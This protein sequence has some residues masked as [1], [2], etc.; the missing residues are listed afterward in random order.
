MSDCCFSRNQGKTCAVHSPRLGR[1]HPPE[2]HSSFLGLSTAAAPALNA[3]LLAQLLRTAEDVAKMQEELENSR[4]L[5]A[6]AAKDTEATIEKIKV[7]L[8]G[9]PALSNSGC[10][11]CIGHGL[12]GPGR[13]CAKSCLIR[14]KN[15]S[16]WLGRYWCRAAL[17][18]KTAS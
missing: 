13:D 7:A 1:E 14:G 11:D 9:S 16:D 2:Q 17:T 5:L 12:E 18:A 10:S 8:L 3:A 6:Q 4:P 15:A